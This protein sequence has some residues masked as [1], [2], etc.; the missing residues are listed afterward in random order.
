MKSYFVAALAAGLFVFAIGS[1]S[2]AAESH[3][4][5]EEV[6]M[7]FHQVDITALA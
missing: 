2:I 4:D 1:S 5:H 3:T 6:T 7:N